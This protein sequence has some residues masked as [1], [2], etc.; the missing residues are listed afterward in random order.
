L[1]PHSK[2]FICFLIALILCNAYLPIVAAF[3]GYRDVPQE[4]WASEYIRELEQLGYT[5][6]MADGAYDP[7]KPVT[8]AEFTA[9]VC[10]MTGMDDT[11]L[12]RGAHWAEAAMEYAKYMGW[13]TQ[14]EVPGADYD[15]PI[16]R[17]MAAKIL[18]LGSFEDHGSEPSEKVELSDLSDIAE[19]FHEYV[20]SAYS[21]GIFTGYPDGT[22]RPK[23]SITRAEAAAIICRAIG[24]HSKA[25]VTGES[26]IVP[27]LIYHHI[28]D[29][30]GD[31]SPKK[32][33]ED[34]ENL[35]KAG[36]T[37]VFLE[38]LQ[39]YVEEGT[40]LPERPVVI[41]FDDGYLSNYQY[42][43]P[44]IRELGMKA[45]IAVIG[46]SAG[47]DRDKDG[48]KIIPHFSW[49]QA[50]E[51]VRSDKIRIHPHSYN[52]HEFS[53]DANVSRVGVLKRPDESY[54]EYIAAFVEDLKKIG[55]MIR[56]KL[57]DSSNV[58]AYPYGESSPITEKLLESLGYDITLGIKDG[59]NVITKGD[60][61]SLRLLKRINAD[62]YEGD[63]VRFIETYY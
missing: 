24:L 46:W 60:K 48:K 5:Q 8:N 39:M 28:S 19:G 42:A 16:S 63:I 43:W 15:E 20:T 18:M 40:Q 27:I 61:S 2:R 14:G 49:E 30:P 36:Y 9:L 21:I 50:S 29:R 1:K 25:P 4:Y 53:S 56:L 44:V 54:G 26:V 45:D 22:F 47:L 52:M 35:K 33:R 59:V 38:D 12:E 41:T 32:F 57:G 31:T 3:A 62:G 6:D 58:F 23:D 17:E 11:V 51:M 55:S 13:F 10:R 37:A 7:E 34:M